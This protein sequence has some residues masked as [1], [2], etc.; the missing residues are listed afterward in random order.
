MHHYAW[1]ISLQDASVCR[2][3]LCAGKYNIRG[4]IIAHVSSIR[5]AHQH[6]WLIDMQ[7]LQMC[8]N[9]IHMHDSSM[10][11]NPIMLKGHDIACIWSKHQIGWLIRMHESSTYMPHQSTITYNVHGPSMRW[12]RRYAWRIKLHDPA[13][14]INHQYAW[15][16]LCMS[17][18][19]ALY[20][21]TH[22]DS[23]STPCNSS[24]YNQLMVAPLYMAH[25]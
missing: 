19:Y 21:N 16:P 20:I 15:A 22:V 23:T 25:T 9:H 14:C 8:M 2:V 10:C 3:H 18:Q 17:H 11:T 24:W 1:I 12:V 6:T 5:M 4:I 7:E 13:L